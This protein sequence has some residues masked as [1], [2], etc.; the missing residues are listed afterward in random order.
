M[1]LSIVMVDV[2]M[3]LIMLLNFDILYRIPY[4]GKLL[5]GL[6]SKTGEFLTHHRWL[7]GLYFFGIMLMVLVPI[8]G[9]GGV[10]GSIAGRLLGMDS[11]RIFLAILA[12]AL[13]GCFAL[14]ISSS[15]LLDSVICPGNFLPVNVAG[16]ICNRTAP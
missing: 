3:A 10:R 6:T 9:S 7:A 2:E 15:Y 14:A 1:A 16:L 13:I 4:V 11:T 5:T 12:G 8:L